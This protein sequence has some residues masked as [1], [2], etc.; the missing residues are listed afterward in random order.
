MGHTV[1]T[2]CTGFIIDNKLQLFLFSKIV[3]YEEYIQRRI[4]TFK[5][6][7]N[8]VPFFF[9][10]GEVNCFSESACDRFVSSSKLVRLVAWIARRQL[11]DPENSGGVVTV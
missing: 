2:S 10:Y 8:G 3:R 7:L 1:H 11:L 9:E 4:D 5:S 6:H